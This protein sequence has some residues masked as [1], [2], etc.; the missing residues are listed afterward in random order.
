MILGEARARVVGSWLMILFY[1]LTILS[2][3]VGLI[4]PW[5]LL[6]VLGIPRLLAVL[7]TFRKPKPAAPPP[8]YPT[9]PLWFVGWAFVHTRRAGALLTLG[10][11]LN[12]LIPIKL[13]WL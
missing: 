8:D 10:L 4:G 7:A 12:V 2:A 5:V 9:W 1:P 3:I 13:P 11:L 6:V